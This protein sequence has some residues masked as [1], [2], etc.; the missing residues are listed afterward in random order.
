MRNLASQLIGSIGSVRSLKRG[1]GTSTECEGNQKGLWPTFLFLLNWD[2]LFPYQIP[3][4][5]TFNLPY[6]KQ[7]ANEIHNL[8][9]L[10]HNLP[11]LPPSHSFAGRKTKKMCWVTKIFTRLIASNNSHFDAYNPITDRQGDGGGAGGEELTPGHEAIP[12]NVANQYDCWPGVA[13]KSGSTSIDRPTMYVYQ[14]QPP[15]IAGY[16]WQRIP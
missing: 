16:R 5:L 8:L 10:R 11:P 6:P 13:N 15:A 4:Y 12:Y 3:N 2:P 1:Q 14:R 7:T 9:F